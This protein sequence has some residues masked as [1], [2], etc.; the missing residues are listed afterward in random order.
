MG[1]LVSL[2]PFVSRPPRPWGTSPHGTL[3]GKHNGGTR[4]VMHPGRDSGANRA[5][6]PGS[7][8]KE[9]PPAVRTHPGGLVEE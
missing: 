2:D 5:S 3:R 9:S 7:G 4:C 8:R 6:L 1:S